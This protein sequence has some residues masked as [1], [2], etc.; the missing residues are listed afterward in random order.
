MQLNIVIKRK[1]FTDNSTSGDLFIDHKFC[2][3]TLEDV[4]RE[5]KGRPVEEWKI[6]GKT[7]IPTGKYVCVITWSNRFKKLL[8]L[9]LDV[10]GF[11]GVRIHSGND[12]EDT[13]G[14]ILVGMTSRPDWI[15]NSRNAF[16]LVFDAIQNAEDIGKTVTVEVA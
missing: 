4:V 15:G 5:V 14:C 3:H 1:N 10:P 16:N 12:A 9:L 11:S 7:A 6:K 8:P 13:E 2:C